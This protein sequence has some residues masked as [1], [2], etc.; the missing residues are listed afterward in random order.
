M[1]KWILYK[2]FD[3]YKLTP[4]ANYNTYGCNASKVITLNNC[5]T[6]NEA[7]DCAVSHGWLEQNIINRTG[8]DY[9]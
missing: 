4:E 9:A 3:V 8:E 2:E 5:K 1:D 7:L 6:V